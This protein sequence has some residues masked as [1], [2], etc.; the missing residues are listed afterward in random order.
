MST[1]S[2]PVLAKNAKQFVPGMAAFA[3]NFTSNLG[4]LKKYKDRQYAHAP[5]EHREVAEE[6][7]TDYWKRGWCQKKNMWVDKELST[8]MTRKD[9]ASLMQFKMDGWRVGAWGLPTAVTGGWG[10]AVL[11]VWLANDTWQP[12]TMPQTPEALA[13]W[14]EA[15]D[16]YRYKYAPGVCT[17]FRWWLEHCAPVPDKFAHG[18]EEL[19]NE[20]N[21]VRRDAKAIAE[22]SPMY[23]C[24]QTM[25]WVRRTQARAMGRAMGFPTFPTLSKISVM[26]RIKDY[27]E[28]AWNEDYMVMKGNLLESMTDEEVQD[29]AWRRYLSPF[30][31]KLTREQVLERIADYHTVL[32]GEKFLETGEAC[33]IYV[34]T[35]F[36]FQHYFE[37]AFLEGDIS[38]LDGNDFEN[39]TQWGKDVYLQ[40]LEFENGPLR[41]QV[42]AYGQKKIE[43]R[44]AKMKAIDGSA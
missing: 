10:L 2:L 1:G 24:F 11:P 39:I 17:A 26:T 18:W 42:E 23:D 43:E 34:L 30:D 20:R 13:E 40:R 31:K 41:D 22:L 8:E 3:G 44:E 25:K 36:C 21:N 9:I 32:G 28:L 5:Q 15:Q 37:P 4:L 6:W 38:E 19:N 35:T 29:Y 14:R 33:N 12:S 7:D 27:W 16:M